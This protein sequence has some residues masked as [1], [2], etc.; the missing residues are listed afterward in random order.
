MA[1]KEACAAGAK[2][3]AKDSLLLFKAA[4]AIGR[5]AMLPAA[6]CSLFAIS[7]F[8]EMGAF[9]Q[10]APR[11]A[12][13]WQ[14]PQATPAINFLDSLNAKGELVKNKAE[15]A[16]ICRIASSNKPNAIFTTSLEAVLEAAMRIA[17]DGVYDSLCATGNKVGVYGDSKSPE[18]SIF[19]SPVGKNGAQFR[20]MVD[21][22]TFAI[23]ITP[24]SSYEDAER[25]Q[26]ALYEFFGC[27]VDM[28]NIYKKIKPQPPPVQQPG[29]EMGEPTG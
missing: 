28:Q 4:A 5:K 13:S 20:I 24:D 6:L 21:G 7:P 29:R 18:K 8:V 26:K 2:R 27:I 15:F 9:A 25:L 19:V 10:E 12:K 22:D 11:N 17:S 3:K 16:K 14:A 23:R 1:E